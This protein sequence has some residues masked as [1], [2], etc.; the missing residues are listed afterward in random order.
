MKNQTSLDPLL[1]SSVDAARMLGVCLRTLLTLTNSGEIPFIRVRRCNRYY[2]DDLR[3]FI[4]R[5]KVTK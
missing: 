4:E 5:N 1:V 3:A 2:V